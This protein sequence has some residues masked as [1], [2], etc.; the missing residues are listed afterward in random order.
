MGGCVC[1]GL[2]GGGIW[3]NF[4]WVSA[5]GLS[6]HLHHFCLFCGHII[7]PILVTFGKM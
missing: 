1:G 7:D 5:A 2:G 4:C 6:E 3:V